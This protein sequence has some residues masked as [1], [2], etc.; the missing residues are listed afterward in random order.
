MEHV[1]IDVHKNQSQICI[2]TPEGELIEK[3]ILTQRGRF[4]AVFGDRPQARIVIEAATESEWVARCLE[5]LGHEVIVADPNY[6]PMYGH[7]T[8]RVKTDR[9]D[10]RK[11]AELLR[12]GLLTEVHPPT[13]AEEAVRDLCRAREHAVEDRTA[14]RHRLGKFL[15]RRGLRWTAGRR[16]WTHA[17]RA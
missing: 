14:C 2:L 4:A 15:Q 12:A 16:A 7:R 6:A 8:R 5:E 17:H 11:L 10:A 1:G 3:R 13:A 9:R